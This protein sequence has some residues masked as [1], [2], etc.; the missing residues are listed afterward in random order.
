MQPQFFRVTLLSLLV[1]PEL[2]IFGETVVVFPK[3]LLGTSYY[4]Q[5]NESNEC[6]VIKYSLS[7]IR[8]KV[9]YGAMHSAMQ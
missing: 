9:R 3:E 4:I 7:L 5:G 1:S 8:Q 2:L 6:S